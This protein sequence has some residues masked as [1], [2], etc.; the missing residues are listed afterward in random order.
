MSKHC[1][2][3]TFFPSKSISKTTPFFLFFPILSKKNQPGFLSSMHEYIRMWNIDDNKEKEVSD[4]DEKSYFLSKQ[5]SKQDVRRIHWTR[6]YGFF[7]AADKTFVFL[8]FASIGTAWKILCWVWWEMDELCLL[9]SDNTSQKV[10]P[11]LLRVWRRRR[12]R[13][14]EERWPDYY[15]QLRI[16]CMHCT[17]DHLS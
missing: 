1:F 17:D 7:C 9:L 3:C 5:E 13:T 15:F 4:H 11:L 6:K 14:D 8:I 16:H 12:R 10:W 2:W